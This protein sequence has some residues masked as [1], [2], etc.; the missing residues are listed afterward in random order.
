MAVFWVRLKS[1]SVIAGTE[2]AGLTARKAGD[3]SD[4]KL[5]TSTSNGWPVQYRAMWSAVEQAP[6]K[7]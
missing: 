7:V 5:R 4:S 1:P 3:L 6:G 2:P